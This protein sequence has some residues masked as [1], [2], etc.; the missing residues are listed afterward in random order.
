MLLKAVKIEDW[1]REWS[2]KLDEIGVGK[3][4]TLPLSSDS[5]YDPVKTGLLESEAEEGEPT[6]H[7]A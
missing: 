5:A 4:R 2:H 1:S 3:I 7:N 6:N